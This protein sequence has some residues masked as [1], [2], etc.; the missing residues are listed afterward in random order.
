MIKLS[1]RRSRMGAWN[2]GDDMAPSPFLC[3]L[4]QAA[5]RL[6]LFRARGG[7]V[8]GRFITETELGGQVV[9][10]TSF[11]AAI[12]LG[13]RAGPQFT[14]DDRELADA[15]AGVESQA[16]RQSLPVFRGGRLPGS[17]G[18]ERFADLLD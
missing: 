7:Q 5:H 3:C 12:R 1:A 14:E 10:A 16:H 4:R 8:A 13:R 17:Q 15:L 6:Q 9:I 11:R 18:R 2:A